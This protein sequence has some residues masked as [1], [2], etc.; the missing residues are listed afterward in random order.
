VNRVLKRNILISLLIVTFVTTVIFL[1]IKTIPQPPV[2]EIRNAREIL[3]NAG[4]NNSAIYSRKLYNEAKIYYDSAMTNWRRENGI[5]IFFRD[6]SN[7][8]K[9]AQLSSEKADQATKYS[10][11]SV[12][13]L[14][15]K[16]KERIDSINNLII[17]INYL[18]TSHPLTSEL[19][20]RIS[21]GKFLLEEAEIAFN[22]GDYLLANRR[23]SDSEYL[24]THAYENS[25]E[26]LKNYFLSYSTWQKW[27]DRTIKESKKNRN[28]SIVID[29]VSRK[30]Y[31]YQNGVLKH[32]FNAE[33][34]K[35]WIG[36][37]RMRGDYATPDGMYKISRK[38][39]SG[40][41]KYYK[42]LLINY[43]DKEDV[44]SF[45]KEV[46]EGSLPTSAKIGGLIEIHGNGGKGTDWTEGCIALTD[47]EIDIIYKI[48]R[49]GTPVTIVG[50]T[51]ELRKILNR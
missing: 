20:N 18:F 5:F 11:T 27:I 33:L 38:L 28:Y 26:M 16:V 45:N 51:V 25:V 44:L 46:S 29:K 23:V 10:T 50:S 19:R 17:G 31:G 24:L 21:N 3:A 14:K 39:E 41:T 22:K 40:K 35:N 1:L 13:L 32:V 49:V 36:D 42:A 6:Y 47:S 2:A 7:V 30:F 4:R 9:Y 12:S 48:V 37:K 15:T 8:K 43:P 34:G